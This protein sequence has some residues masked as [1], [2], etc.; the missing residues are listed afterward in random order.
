M[1]YTFFEKKTGSGVSVIEQ[2]LE[3]LHKLVTK[4]F[5]KGIVCARFKDNAWAADLAEIE[6]M[7]SK[8]K[9]VKYFLCITMFSLNMRGLNL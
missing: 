1:V 7:S 8:Y 5:K 3:E 6:S 9:N 2:L 4:K